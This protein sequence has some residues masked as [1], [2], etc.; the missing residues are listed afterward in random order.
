MKTTESETLLRHK[1]LHDS[2]YNLTVTPIQSSEYSYSQKTTFH[3]IGKLPKLTM[4]LEKP[5]G[6]LYDFKGINHTMT[7]RITTMVPKN[8][9]FKPIPQ[10]PVTEL[11]A[12]NSY[13][14]YYQPL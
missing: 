6:L 1:E 8:P 2:N 12:A 4:R 10:K 13:I 5:S 3:P 7:I 11:T 9:V 14:Q